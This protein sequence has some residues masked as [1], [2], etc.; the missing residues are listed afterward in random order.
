[1]SLWVFKP[2]LCHLSPFYLLLVTVVLFCCFKTMSLVRILFYQGFLLI[3]VR[4]SPSI[5]IKI[6]PTDLY[7]F[8]Y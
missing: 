6:H 7:A 1:M 4:L 8:P 3:E 5:C 2:S